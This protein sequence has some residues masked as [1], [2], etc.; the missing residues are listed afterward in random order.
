MINR[1]VCLRLRTLG[2]A[3]LCVVAGAA[4]AQTM[5]LAPLP[6]QGSVITLACGGIGKD[7]S[8]AMR[9]ME[10]AHALMILFIEQGGSYIT[11]VAT[12][13]DDPLGDRAIARDCGPIGLLDVPEPGRYRVTATY[14]GVTREQWVTLTP[15]GGARLVLSW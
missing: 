15:M 8:D 13:V 12:R 10:K 4:G 7:E 1:K 6:P 5:P 9:A 3:A 14:G 2:L 11:G